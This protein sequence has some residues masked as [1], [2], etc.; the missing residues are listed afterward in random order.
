MAANIA[1][2]RAALCMRD[3]FAA[4]LGAESSSLVDAAKS[5]DRAAALA[6]IEQKVNVNRP[7]PD[8]THRAA[9]GRA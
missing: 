1:G 2:L 5:G 6:M 9:V 4:D 3:R 8:G 7:R